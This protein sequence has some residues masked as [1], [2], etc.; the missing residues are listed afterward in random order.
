MLFFNRLQRWLWL[1]SF[2]YVIHQGWTLVWYISRFLFIRHYLGNPFRFQ[3]PPLTYMLKFSRYM[4][5][6]SGPENCCLKNFGLANQRLIAEGDKQ[7]TLH[8]SIGLYMCFF[9]PGPRVTY[10]QT[11]WHGVRFAVLCGESASDKKHRPSD[12]QL[13]VGAPHAFNDLLAH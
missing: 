2:Q 1:T 11:Q 3:L 10:M 7:S 9:L 13:N 8:R 6:T 4:S 12:A 5:L